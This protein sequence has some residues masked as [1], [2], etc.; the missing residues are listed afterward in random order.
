MAANPSSLTAPQLLCG[1]LEAPDQDWLDS[2][3]TETI[4]HSFIN[5]PHYSAC[6]NAV[7]VKAFWGKQMSFWITDDLR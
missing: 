6:L 2:L 3:L 5:N 1:R 4:H 7:G